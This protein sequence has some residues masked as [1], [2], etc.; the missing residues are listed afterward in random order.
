MIHKDIRAYN[1]SQTGT[2]KAICALLCKEIDASLP[3]AENKV[4]H[5]G[6]VW[7]L[8]ENPVAGY[9]VR[10]DGVWLMFWSGQSFDEPGLISNSAKFKSAGILYTSKDEI[11]LKDLKRWLRK[12]KTTQWDYK[13]LIKR[14]GKLVRLK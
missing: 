10:K 9:W 1:N 13:N 8:D 12:A 11:S 3:K 2:S 6:P 5:G 4:W 7:F 14:K